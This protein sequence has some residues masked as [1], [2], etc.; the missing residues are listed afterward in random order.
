MRLLLAP[1]NFAC[2]L[3]GL[4]TKSDNGQV[5]RMFANTVF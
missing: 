2:T 5:F 1:G 3:A 4:E